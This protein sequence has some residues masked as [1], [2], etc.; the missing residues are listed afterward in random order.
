M[1]HQLRTQGVAAL[2]AWRRVRGQFPEAPKVNPQPPASPS[3]T[4]TE[5]RDTSPTDYANAW[6]TLRAQTP[7]SLVTVLTII[8]I[9]QQ[10]FWAALWLIGLTL[11]VLVGIFW[12]ALG[13]L[14]GF[15]AFSR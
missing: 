2:E 10:L 12:F 9:A 11:R 13:F 1:Y 6:Q 5:V 7:I 14:L 3:I 8:W 4:Q 15:R